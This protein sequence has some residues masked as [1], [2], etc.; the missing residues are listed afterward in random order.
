MK[1]A[2]LHWAKDNIRVSSVN[3]GFIET[4]MIAPFIEGVP[5]ETDAMR[6]LILTS[7]PMGR[8]GRAAEVA[9]AIAF[10]ASP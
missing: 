6:N 9:A 7:T 2:A 10:L 8:V 3:P 4:L 5:P 1:N